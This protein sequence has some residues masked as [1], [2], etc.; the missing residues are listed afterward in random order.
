VF[1]LSA[2]CS[3]VSSLFQFCCN[4]HEDRIKILKRS[5]NNRSV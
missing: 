5:S 1:T 3:F 4:V 2:A